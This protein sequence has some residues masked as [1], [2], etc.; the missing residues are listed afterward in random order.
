MVRF[1]GDGWKKT[2]RSIVDDEADDMYA[3]CM[4]FLDDLPDSEGEDLQ[5]TKQGRWMSALIDIL[6][7]EFGEQCVEIG[8]MGDAENLQFKIPLGVLKKVIKEKNGESE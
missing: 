2:F 6:T 5:D 1:I 3:R 4:S 8:A 7:G